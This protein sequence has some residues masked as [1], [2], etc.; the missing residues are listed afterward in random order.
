MLYF[1]D[2][3]TYHRCEAVALEEFVQFCDDG[4]LWGE[5]RTRGRAMRLGASLVSVM[6]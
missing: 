5:G 2:R 4:F 3:Y 1:M 6:P